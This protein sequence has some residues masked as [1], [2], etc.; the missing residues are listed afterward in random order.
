MKAADIRHHINRHQTNHC[1]ILAARVGAESQPQLVVDRVL[2]KCLA[3][4]KLLVLVWDCACLYLETQ[5]S[6]YSKNAIQGKLGALHFKIEVSILPKKINRQFFSRLNRLF[7]ILLLLVC[8]K[9]I[10]ETPKGCFYRYL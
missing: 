1:A 2:E 10:Q 8:V 9:S 3:A 5:I 7:N 6:F 4:F